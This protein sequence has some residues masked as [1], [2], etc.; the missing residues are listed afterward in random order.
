MGRE[1]EEKGKRDK[2]SSHSERE[3]EWG[4]GKSV[5]WKEAPSV[6]GW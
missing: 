4:G 1:R 6:L 3:R 5:S 2:E